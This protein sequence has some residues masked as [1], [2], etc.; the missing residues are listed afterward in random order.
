MV[1]HILHAVMA[2]TIDAEFKDG[3]SGQVLIQMGRW[4]CRLD[5]LVSR[6]LQAIILG[7]TPLDMGA[8]SC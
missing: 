5:A 6:V 8:V 1:T 7:S 4:K 2:A 3:G